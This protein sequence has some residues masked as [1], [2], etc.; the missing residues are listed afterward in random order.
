MS[1]QKRDYEAIIVLNLQ[2]EEGIDDKI[3]AVGRE[4]EDEGGKLEKIDR[5]GKRDFAY[6]ARKKKSGYYVNYF[7]KAAP[8]TIAKLRSRLR[9][10]PDIYLQSYQRT[11]E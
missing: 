8:D 7:F 5:I 9:I 4:I 3:N 1:E 11:A 10:N 6:N 2:G